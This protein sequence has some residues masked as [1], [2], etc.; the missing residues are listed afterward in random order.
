MHEGQFLKRY[1][2]I[3]PIK[4]TK[5]VELTGIK[6]AT[7]YTHF[8]KEKLDS[9]TKELYSKKIGIIWNDKI[10]TPQSSIINDDNKIEDYNKTQQFQSTA[11]LIGG[12]P[13]PG[14][15]TNMVPL[16][17]NKYGL[18]VPLIPVKAY[19]GYIDNFGDPEFYETLDKYNVSVVGNHAGSYFAYVVKG[20]SMENWT[21]EEMARLSIPEDYI[22]TARDLPRHH[23]LNRLHLHRWDMY[24]IVQHTGI[25][26]KQVTEHN[27]DEGWIIC[28]SLNPDKNKYPDIKVHFNDCLQILNVVHKATAL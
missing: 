8:A 9:L 11:M 26:I 23:W 24:V 17:N 15:E 10:D 7:I 12:V 14:S 20:D 16:G 25:I 28:H 19:A 6:R 18:T 2:K 3:T 21:S 27:V 4:V 22:V 5:V 1:I 13:G